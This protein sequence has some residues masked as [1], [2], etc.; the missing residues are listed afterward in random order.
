VQAAYLKDGVRAAG[1]ALAALAVTVGLLWFAPPSTPV[2]PLVEVT[3]TNGSQVCG[4]LL[5]VTPGATLIRRAS[6][7]TAIDIAPRSIVA[8]TVVTAC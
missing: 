8:L 1:A 3:L 4:T 2:V 6:D 7:G 5:P